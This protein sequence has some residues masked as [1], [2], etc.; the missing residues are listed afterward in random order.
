[1]VDGEHSAILKFCESQGYTKTTYVDNI[2]ELTKDTSLNPDVRKTLH[3]TQL[4]FE[5]KLD[6]NDVAGEL[7]YKQQHNT[8]PSKVFNTL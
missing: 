3:H 4:T 6:I 5:H 8:R 2:L 7:V 1:M